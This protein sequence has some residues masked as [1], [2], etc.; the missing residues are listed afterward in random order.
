[1][2]GMSRF[3]AS[4][5]GGIALVI[6]CGLGALPAEATAAPIWVSSQSCTNSLHDTLFEAGFRGVNL[7]EAWAIAMR[8]SNGEAN[9]GPG[10]PRFNGHD[11]GLFQWNKPSWGSQSWWNDSKM[12]NGLYN[13]R[14]AYRMSSGGRDWSLWGLDG[15]GRTKADLYANYGWSS[16]QIYSWI[17]QPYERYFRAFSATLGRCR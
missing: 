1:M 6:V 9:L 2:S 13:A 12:V 7:H 5:L 10:S 11:W 14:L 4:I 15:R 3:R 16:Q 8:E 17:T